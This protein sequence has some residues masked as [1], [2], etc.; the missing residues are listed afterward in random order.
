MTQRR[1]LALGAI[2]VAVLI[3]FF[4]SHSINS[5]AAQ[6]RNNAQAPRLEVD[7]LW[8]KPLPDHQILGSVTGVAVDG[9][10]HIWAVH[11]GLDSLGANEK[12]PTL[13]PPA[14]TCC[15]SAPAV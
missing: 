10:D 12:G 5:T 13:T 14:A 3:T 7:P 11:R 2:F 15:F 4:L 1:R 8:P 9:Q 6:A